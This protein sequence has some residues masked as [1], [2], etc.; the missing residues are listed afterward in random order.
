MC[1]QSQRVHDV[2]A[3]GGGVHHPLK[4]QQRCIFLLHSD[5]LDIL[6]HYVK[7]ENNILLH[8]VRPSQQLGALVS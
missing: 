4:Q 6:L 5:K 7:L 2:T 8:Y 3:T 1:N